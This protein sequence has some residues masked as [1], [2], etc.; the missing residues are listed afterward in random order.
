MIAMEMAEL[1]A[2]LGIHPKTLTDLDVAA[3]QQLVRLS[4]EDSGSSSNKKN[5]KETR[6]RKNRNIEG[7]DF[8]DEAEFDPS[9]QSEITSKMI[10]DIFGK[11]EEVAR[12]R[13]KRYRS[14]DDDEAS[15]F[16]FFKWDHHWLARA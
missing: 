7:D 13:K 5:Q 16:A 4:G 14:L 12:P 3:A 11:E 1:K 15:M 2:S 8:E 10:E 9:S 6:R